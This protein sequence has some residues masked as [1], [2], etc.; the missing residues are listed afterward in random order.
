MFVLSTPEQ[1]EAMLQE[2]CDI[3]E[4]I[5][6]ELGLHFQM[7]VISPHPNIWLGCQEDKFA[8]QEFIILRVVL[9]PEGLLHCVLQ[10]Y[11]P[12]FEDDHTAATVVN[13]L[14]ECSIVLRVCEPSF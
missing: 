2:L 8:C 10:G 3:E 11:P 6:T 4:E 5:F 1:S 7:L 14:T 13:S 9:F 12:F